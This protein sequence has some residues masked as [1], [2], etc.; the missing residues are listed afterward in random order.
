MAPPLL[1]L[2]QLAAGYHAPGLLSLCCRALAN[3]GL[4][5]AA[6]QYS[7]QGGKA[8]WAT[9]RSAGRWY[10]LA[11]QRSLHPVLSCCLCT[12]RGASFFLLCFQ[13]VTVLRQFA[14]YHASGLLSL[15][16]RA[17]VYRGLARAAH[18]YSLQGGKAIWA[19]KQSAGRWYVLATQRSLHPVLS[20]CLCTARGTSFFLLCCQPVTVRRLLCART[21]QLTPRSP[22]APRAC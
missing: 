17:P 9:K 3:R 1:V 14:G 15:C 10:V 5:R 22:C 18:Q 6:H 12:A 7:L 20:C 16:R 8:I 11:T 2:Y 21:A 13:P 19:A 4:A